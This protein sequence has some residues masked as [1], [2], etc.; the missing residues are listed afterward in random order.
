MYNRCFWTVAAG[1]CLAYGLLAVPNYDD[2]NYFYQLYNTIGFR[3]P[4][5]SDFYGQYFHFMKP[6]TLLYALLHAGADAPAFR[7]LALV[8]SAEIFVCLWLL[9]LCARRYATPEAAQAGVCV[10]FYLLVGHWALSPLRPETTILLCC[11][12]IFWLCERFRE[13]GSPALLIGAS[14]IAFLVALPMHTCGAIP[15]MYLFLFAS[16]HVRQFSRKTLVAFAVLSCVFAAA[17]A[18]MVIYPGLASLAGSLAL[19]SFDGN[20]FG[21]LRGEYARVSGFVGN[22]VFLPL[23]LFMAS[24][25]LSCLAGAYARIR[26][27][28]LRSRLN[29]VLFLLA[30]VVGLG[31]LPSATWEVYVVYYYPSLVLLFAAA[32]DR[33]ARRRR[34]LFVFR[35]ALALCAVLAFWR[36]CGTMPA[37]YLGLCAAGFCLAAG[38]ASRLPAARLPVLIVVPLLLYQAVA[39]LSTKIIFDRAEQKIKTTRG[40]ILGGSWFVF[41]GD[42][43]FSVNADWCGA[44]TRIS[45]GANGAEIALSPVAEER[46]G[47]IAGH[48]LVRFFGPARQQDQAPAWTSPRPLGTTFYGLD[49]DLCNITA[50]LQGQS[51]PLRYRAVKAIR[52]SGDFLDRYASVVVRGLR[53]VEYRA[54]G[55]AP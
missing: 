37:L 47:L 45:T 52:L 54:Q 6:A 17:G 41:F 28:S 25:A 4:F 12:A 27:R 11:L 50:F 3:R 14:A 34:S 48:S 9:Y 33:C 1:A 55:P 29:I 22:P 20:R 13:I 46:A 24:V 35:I 18:A 36:S 44:K 2:G 21:G 38:C 30:A 31:V 26:M 51:P 15:C 49:S 5:Y 40:V 10:M 32:L 8:Q 42:N 23:I 7:I 43:V 19:F 16:V 39:M 53:F